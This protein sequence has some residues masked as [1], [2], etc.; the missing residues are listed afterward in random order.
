MN[1]SVTGVALKEE[2]I[3]A[4]GNLR[5]PYLLLPD[6]MLAREAKLWHDA[7]RSSDKV[8]DLAN[9]NGILG[10]GLAAD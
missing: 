10:N 4:R 8:F 7:R 6:A 2:D 5:L 3:E 1:D 9:V